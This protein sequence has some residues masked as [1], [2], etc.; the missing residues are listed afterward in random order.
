MLDIGY[1][2]SAQSGKRLIAVRLS[3]SCPCPVENPLLA[4]LRRTI[5]EGPAFNTS[6]SSSTRVGF[7]AKQATRCAQGNGRGIGRRQV[8]AQ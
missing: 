2:G 3:A 6:S 4:T 7:R 1:R 8:G 5:V